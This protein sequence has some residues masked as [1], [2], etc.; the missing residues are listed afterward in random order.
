[1]LG[2]K[3][4]EIV[5]HRTR[6]FAS[7]NLQKAMMHKD[8]AWECHKKK[9]VSQ[10]FERT[11]KTHA[12]GKWNWR[13][14][15]LHDK[16][17]NDMLKGMSWSQRQLSKNK[18]KRH[19]FSPDSVNAGVVLRHWK[20]RLTATTAGYDFGPQPEDLR[21]LMDVQDDGEKTVLTPSGGHSVRP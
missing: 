12:K 6:A 11:K 2:S 5:P 8:E 21:E 18:G 14:D 13:T 20:I 15:T 19:E 1:M 7:K 4:G 10:R 17:D 16:L 3:Q 9:N